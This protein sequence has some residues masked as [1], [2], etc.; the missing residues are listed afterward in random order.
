MF[1]YHSAIKSSRHS[2][3]QLIQSSCKFYFQSIP[4]IDSQSN[5][6]NILK[7]M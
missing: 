5:C 4:P 2:F 3:P 6:V 7:H 1:N